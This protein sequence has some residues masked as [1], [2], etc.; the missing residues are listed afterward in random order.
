M[1]AE[2]EIFL[3]GGDVAPLNGGA[4]VVHPAKAAALAAAE[5]SGALGEHSPPSFS[6]F[7]DVIR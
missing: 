1:E 4:E 7:L 5:K 6:F 2:D 3:V